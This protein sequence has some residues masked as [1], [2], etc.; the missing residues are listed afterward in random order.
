MALALIPLG[1]DSDEQYFLLVCDV[2]ALTSKSNV[3]VERHL[4]QSALSA[5]RHHAGTS[6]LHALKVLLSDHYTS[7]EGVHAHAQEIR[8]TIRQIHTGK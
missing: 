6:H 2:M 1:D 3:P 5:C 7:V 4:P 8:S